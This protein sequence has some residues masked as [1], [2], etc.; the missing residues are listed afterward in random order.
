MFTSE[1]LVEGNIYT[2]QE[3]QE[4]FNIRDATIRTGVFKP[5]IHQSIW[6]FVTETKTPDRPQLHDYLEGNILR[7]D[8]QPEGRTD[9]LVIEH[10]VNGLELLIFYRK[11]KNAL[12]NYGFKYEGRFRYVSHEG[13]H[14]T[15]FILRRV[16]SILATVV[17]DLE[18]IKAEESS[19]QGV[20]REG[21]LTY[22]LTNKHER[23]PNLRA[24]SIQV[25]GTRCQVCGFSFS[26]V[27]GS[28]GDGFIEVHHLYPVSR[29]TGEVNVSP[30]TDMAVVCANCHRMIHRN[31]EKPL[32]LED[33]RQIVE[34]QKIKREEDI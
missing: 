5:A 13:S 1:Q 10:E 24:A 19:F 34:K 8:G 9:K 15:R 33:L 32:I 30:S 17:K 6:L 31:P 7:W 27:Y 11:H 12:P 14:P 18:A 20:F 26:E 23:N 2:R 25:H 16:G 3:L 4:K 29:Y 22:V 21:K 28:L